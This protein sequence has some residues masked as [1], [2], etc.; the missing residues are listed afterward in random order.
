MSGFIDQFNAATKTAMTALMDDATWIRAAGGVP[1]QIKV[2]FSLET[3]QD[4]LGN[5]IN[6]AEPVA[7]CYA[8]DVVGIA[9]GD[10]IDVQGEQYKVID[11]LPTGD[12]MLSLIMRRF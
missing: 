9:A 5:D 1:V 11:P 4:E 7:K 2:E 3:L 8:D 6:I 10:V 12:G